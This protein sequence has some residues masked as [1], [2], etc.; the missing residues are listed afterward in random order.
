MSPRNSRR[1]DGALDAVAI[2]E[3]LTRNDMVGARTVIAH[4]DSFSTIL[5]LATAW[6]ALT[7]MHALDADELIASMRKA[8]EERG[9]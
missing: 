9:R 4:C 2:L 5:A 3:S 8:N 6:M 7:E 1:D